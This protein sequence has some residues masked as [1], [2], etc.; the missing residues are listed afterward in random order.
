MNILVTGCA[1]YIGSVLARTLINQGYTVYG[2][3]ALLYGDHGISELLTNPRFTVYNADIRELASYADILPRVDAIVHLA[4]IVGDPACARQP[5]L[6]EQVNWLA[7]K[8]LFDAAKDA[9]NVKRFIFASTCSNYGKMTGNAY[10]DERSP[11]RPVSLYARLKVKA[12]E[13]ILASLPR[14]GFSPTVLRFAT[15]YGLSP[16]M[17]FDLTVNEFARDAALG[18]ELEVYGPHFWRPYCH[19]DDIAQACLLAIRAEQSLIDHE[20]FNVGD[21]KDNYTK[22][23]ITEHLL[24]FE[25]RAKIRFIHKDEDPRDYRVNFSKIKN[26]L[27]YVSAKQFARGVRE[28]LDTVRN[29]SFPDPYAP[30]YHN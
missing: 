27:N 20:V 5:E 23:D 30:H 12:E 2:L 21:T 25:P 4:A 8:Q 15:A 3:D 29:G 9:P 11:L 26:V 17:R 10:V 6:A 13:Y 24:A 14:K 1:G 16:R 7:T 19:V 22:K 28:I 18:K